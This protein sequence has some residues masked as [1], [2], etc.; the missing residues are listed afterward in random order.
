MRYFNWKKIYETGITEIDRQH[1]KLFEIANEYYEELFSE[2][3]IPDNRRMFKILEKLKSYS[4]Y[5]C[6]YEKEVFP[7]D[8]IK[9]YF[10]IE[11]MLADKI[12]E[13]TSS[14]N[15]NNIVVLYG[16]AEFLRK[17]LLKH[18]LVLNTENFKEILK[19]EVFNLS[20]N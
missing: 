15:E 16:F 18:I 10:D 19:K 1:K 9:K 2:T 4:E 14:Y 6:R 3:F 13:L 17:W 11:N 7:E 8:I 20:C 5:H 12:T